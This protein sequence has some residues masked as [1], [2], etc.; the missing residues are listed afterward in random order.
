MKILLYDAMKLRLQVMH[1]KNKFDLK[2]FNLM[3][4][5]GMNTYGIIFDECFHEYL[6]LLTIAS[7]SIGVPMVLFYF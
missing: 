6:D 1:C 2:K 4:Y 3:H 7:F 5:Y